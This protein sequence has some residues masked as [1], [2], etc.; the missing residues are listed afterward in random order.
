MTY[1]VSPGFTKCSRSR[2][3]SRTY[4][5]SFHRAC[6]CSS[7]ATR[8]RSARSCATRSLS[9]ARC[10][11]YCCSGT[12]R[13]RTTAQTAIANTAAREVSPLR[14]RFPASS[15]AR[16]AAVVR[17]RRWTAGRRSRPDRRDVLV[18]RGAGRWR[19]RRIANGLA[20]RFRRGRLLRQREGER[21][22]VTRGVIELFLDAQQLVVLRDAFAPG[23]RTG[24]DLSAVGRN[25]EVGD[26]RVLGLTRAV[27]HHAR[28]PI[29]VRE[30]D[31]VERLGQ[32][33]DLVD[34]D[35]QRVAGTLAD[36]TRE[37]LRIR[38]EDV[39]TDEL[40]AVSELS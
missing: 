18:R 17:V 6:C 37:P 33:A 35:E 28:V 1:A 14:R 4:A 38:D 11:K 3:C 30:A 25:G 9:C 24:L 27:A 36:A 29:A 19:G 21:P 10:A 23:R 13:V 26:R 31:R 40:D 22:G 5:G 15:A 39:V 7:A 12:A 2:A 16:F 20:R 8:A 32:S 34:L